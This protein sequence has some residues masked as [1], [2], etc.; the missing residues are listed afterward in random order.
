M[1]AMLP[2]PLVISLSSLHDFYAA[3]AIVDHFLSTVKLSSLD[4]YDINFLTH[5]LFLLSLLLALLPLPNFEM[6]E[7]L[8]APLSIVCLDNFM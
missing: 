8:I 5:R 1:I 2:N 3:F 6:S 4:F 7:V